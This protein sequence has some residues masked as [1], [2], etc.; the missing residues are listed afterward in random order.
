MF[1]IALLMLAVQNFPQP[2]GLAI[3]MAE[4]ALKEVSIPRGVV[5]GYRSIQWI[6]VLNEPLPNV[7]A[8]AKDN[9]TFKD[10]ATE[11]GDAALMRRGFAFSERSVGDVIQKISITKG[12]YTIKR[13]VT[14]DTNT[15]TSDDPGRTVI[16]VTES[17]A[18]GKAPLENWPSATKQKF[19]MPTLPSTI[20]GVLKG[21]PYSWAGYLTANTRKSQFVAVFRDTRPFET[22]LSAVDTTLV[23]SGGWSRSL[24]SPSVRFTPPS[25]SNVDFVEVSP[26]GGAL[27]DACAV[28]VAWSEESTSTG[29]TIPGAE[30]LFRR[31][32]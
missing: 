26:S 28:S 19:N 29:W 18:P 30:Y 16:T 32:E 1:A 20:K 3:E 5:N 25:G 4:D 2:Q 21:S 6:F 31:I 22:I 7:V 13:R 14:G 8:R 15:V 11:I 27:T 23:Q 10:R 24:P 12:S 9:L 17:V